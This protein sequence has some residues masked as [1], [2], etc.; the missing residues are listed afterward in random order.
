MLNLRI[1]TPLILSPVMCS[2]ANFI[3]ASWFFLDI[4]GFVEGALANKLFS[5]SL[6]ETVCLETLIPRLCL[7]TF[8]ISV[9]VANLFFLDNNVNHLSVFAVVFLGLPGDFFASH[10]PVCSNFFK[11]P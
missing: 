4:N 2:I 5:L 9:A 8:A 6:C 11:M 10:D 3:C 1:T 7:T